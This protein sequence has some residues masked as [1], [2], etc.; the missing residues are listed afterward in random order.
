MR[1]QIWIDLPKNPTKKGDIEA[2]KVLYPNGEHVD[3]TE[4]FPIGEW[5]E[6][7]DTNR[8]QGYIFVPPGTQNSIASIVKEV[9]KERYNFNLK[10]EAFKWC[11]VVPPA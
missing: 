10:N 9:L 5:V 11:H 7:Y 3:L 8:W 4:V 1:E 2:A 6:L